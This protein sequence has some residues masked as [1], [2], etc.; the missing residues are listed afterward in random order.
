MFLKCLRPKLAFKAAASVYSC[1]LSLL[2]GE[3]NV[4][5]EAVLELTTQDLRHIGISPS[6]GLL[7]PRSNPQVCLWDPLRRRCRQHGCMLPCHH[8][9]GHWRLERPDVHIFSFNRPD[10]LLATDLGVCKGMRH[11]YS[12]DAMPQP[13]QMDKERVVVP[14]PEWYIW[15]LIESK[16]PQPPPAIPI[17][18]LALPEH[19]DDFMLKQQ[20]QHQRHSVF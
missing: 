8:S 11:V 1:F 2:G 14:L 5:P 13:S 16:A 18:S 10:V 7:P 19:S 4:L 6:Q 15:W 12:L 3:H 17:G 20:H 9:Q